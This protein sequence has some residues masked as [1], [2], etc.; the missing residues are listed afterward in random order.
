MNTTPPALLTDSELLSETT[1]VVGCDRRTTAELLA[2]L[3]EID[4]RRLYRGEGCSSLFTYCTEVLHLSEPAAYS[5]ITA[6]RLARRF[7]VILALLGDGLVTLTTITMLARHLTEENH[8]ALL[9]AARH[10]SKREIED[11]VAAIDPQPDVASTVRKLPTPSRVEGPTLSRVEGPAPSGVEGPAPIQ[12][13]MDA[14]PLLIQELASVRSATPPVRR[15]IVAPLAPERYLIKVTVSRATRDK[16][17]RA[18]DL[19]R[20]TIP[21]GDPAAIV[22]RAL[23]VLLEELEKAK[24]ASTQRPRSETPTATNGRSVPAAVKRAVWAR[25]TGRCAFVGGKGRCTE[26][27]FLEFH[28]VVPFA[29]GGATSVENLQ[30]RCRSHNAYEAACYFEGGGRP[31]TTGAHRQTGTLSGQS[32]RLGAVGAGPA[33]AIRNREGRRP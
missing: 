24:L 3:A 10:K 18:R 14:T 23:T 22:D 7:P 30:L 4:S 32:S 12:P 13:R 20:H 19:L 17:E 2:L 9:E 16:L 28:H 1:R 29:A 31:V 27:G 26:T 33:T 5:R 6:A 8:E 21:N 11:L 25:D 15:G